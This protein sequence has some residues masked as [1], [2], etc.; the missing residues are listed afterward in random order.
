[1]KSRLLL[2][3]L[4][5]A[6]VSL[7]VAQDQSG[8]RSRNRRGP[9]FDAEGNIMTLNK[10]D[11]RRMGDLSVGD[12]APDFTLK[13]ADGQATVQLSAFRGTRDVALVFGSYT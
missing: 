13:S 3:S 5:L 1:M 7:V 9:K 4:V 10:Y 12:E 2:G 8:D 6:L 11:Q